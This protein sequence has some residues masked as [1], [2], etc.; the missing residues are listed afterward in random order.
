MLQYLAHNRRCEKCQEKMWVGYSDAHVWDSCLNCGP[1]LSLDIAG[2]ITDYPVPQTPLPRCIETQNLR[3]PHS[4][5]HELYYR[6]KDPG[7]GRTWAILKGFPPSNT[8][9]PGYVSP[10]VASGKA[11]VFCNK[12]R[13]N[14]GRVMLHFGSWAAQGLAN[15]KKPLAIPPVGTTVDWEVNSNKK[16][17]YYWDRW[18]DK[19]SSTSS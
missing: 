4:L 10:I 5:P 13:L 17:Y 3:S 11:K 19:T 2:Y 8:I 14:Q 9:T 7:E 16:F 6:I 15:G 18:A 12:D 1:V